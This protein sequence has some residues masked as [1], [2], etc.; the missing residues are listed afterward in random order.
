M[1]GLKP[2]FI[3]FQEIVWSHIKLGCSISL[4][5]CFHAAICRLRVA[6]WCMQSSEHA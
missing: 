2:L 3:T 1:L 4:E 5:V 6:L